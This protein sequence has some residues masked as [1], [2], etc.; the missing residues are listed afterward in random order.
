MREQP[1]GEAHRR[2]IGGTSC[3][4]HSPRLAFRA[5]YGWQSALH[6][7][8]LVNARDYVLL[9]NELAANGADDYH[10]PGVP[11]KSTYNRPTL[12]LNSRLP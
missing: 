2:C 7:I 4:A 6:K 11:P 10:Q 8:P 1:L 5:Y 9:A 3:A 12:R